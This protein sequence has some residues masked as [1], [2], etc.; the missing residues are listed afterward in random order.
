[1]A[2]YLHI[3]GKRVGDRFC[4]KGKMMKIEGIAVQRVLGVPEN[5]AQCCPIFGHSQWSSD[6]SAAPKT[7]RRTSL[8]LILILIFCA[9]GCSSGKSG[10]GTGTSLLGAWT[11]TGNLGTQS[12]SETYQVTLVSSPCSAVS[13]VGTFSVQGPVCFIA[14]N[15]TGQGSISGKG[16]LSNANNTGEGVIIGATANPVPA[17]STLNLLF[18]LG[19]KNGTFIEFTG[20]GTVANGTMTGSGT[21]SASTPVCQGMSATFSGTQQ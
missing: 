16:L 7:L 17:N 18:V 12:G 19:E 14:N 6:G 13:P 20:N 8:I 2:T 4:R 11:V 10:M 3:P 5:R 1:M 9:A 15:N 21:C